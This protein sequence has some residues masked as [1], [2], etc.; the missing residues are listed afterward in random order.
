M[1]AADAELGAIADRRNAIESL[2]LSLRS[3]C[4]SRPHGALIQR[5]TLMPLL[6]SIEDWLWSDEANDATLQ[7]VCLY[8][9]TYMYY[10]CTCQ[11]QQLLYSTRALH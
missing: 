8:E 11:T 9:I 2:C 7:Q 4:D 10:T 3:A 6:D 1:A 5:D